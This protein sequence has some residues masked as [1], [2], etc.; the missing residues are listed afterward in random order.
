MAPMG[1]NFGDI[2]N[3]G[4][5]DIY[6]GTGDMSY[7]GLDVNLMFKNVDGLRF[8]DVTTSS[9]TGH[10]QKGH[11]VSFA[12]WDGDGDLD[13]FVELGGATPGDQAYNALFQN[14]GLGRQWLKVKL[15]GTKTNR[16]A[17]GAKI[18]VD[19]KSADGQMRSIYRTVGNNSSFGG[20][21]LVEMIGLGDETLRR[22]GHGLLADEQHDSNLSRP[23]RRPNDRNQGGFEHL[24]GPAT[25]VSFVRPTLKR[26][27]APARPQPISRG[28]QASMP[29]TMPDN[30]SRRPPGRVPLSPIAAVL[31]ALSFGL[32]AG[33]LDLGII[34]FKK[35]CWNKEGYFRTGRDFLW[36]VP[37]GHAV[38]LMIPGLLVAVVNRLRSGLVS[39]RAGLWLFATL[40]I[41]AA[42]LRLPLFIAG[43]LLLA[44]GLG[45]VVS[46]AIAERGLKPRMARYAV[47]GL[48]G[49]LIVLAAISSGWRTLEEYRAVAKLPPTT[50]GARNVVLIVWDTV[51]AYNL[52][53]YGY[54]RDTTPNL[55]RWA[56]EGCPV[57]PRPAPAP[58]TYPSHSCFFTGQWPFKLNSQ[59]NFTLDAPD[60][61]LA[62][63]LA[64]RG[65]Q[66]AGFAANTSYC[67]Y[68]TGLG[69]GFAHFEDY[70]LSAR[71]LL[72]RT[73]PGSWVLENIL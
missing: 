51:R 54:P 20:N 52:S 48:V 24:Q 69:R 56:T 44:A 9:G 19:V 63:Y 59:W 2:D 38:L 55:T 32:C 53:L 18:R 47:A 8:D 16:A 65:Y 49:V 23:G 29:S 33:Y 11:G 1:A 17:L 10:L 40:A 66:T 68:E 7:E 36:T 61:T 60:P 3:D 27:T 21:S 31:M 42:L 70:A 46:D 25:A 28:V 4:Y 22:R 71:A 58:W 62:E 5:L 41:T 72:S 50:A 26:P 12:D 15:V 39:L 43:N 37:V 64:S 13:L 14:P 35:V 45:R 57:Q 30:A 6:L 34:L 67:S 73:V